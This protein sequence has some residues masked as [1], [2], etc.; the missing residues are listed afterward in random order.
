MKLHSKMIVMFIIF[1]GC[2]W[3]MSSAANSFSWFGGNYRGYE[4]HANTAFSHYMSIN[5][6]LRYSYMDKDGNG[7]GPESPRVGYEKT[8][9]YG[10]YGGDRIFES[11]YYFAHRPTMEGIHYASSYERY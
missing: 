7:L 3:F 2:I 8:D 1:T 6:H 11:L 4:G 10:E 5:E 9:L